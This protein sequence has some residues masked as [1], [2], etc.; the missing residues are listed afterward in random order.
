[1]PNGT[2]TWNRVSS[3]TL[4]VVVEHYPGMSRPAP[5][6]NRVSVP[7]RNGDL[8]FVQDAFNNV[9]RAYEIYAGARS[10]DQAPA[11][12]EDVMS[13]LC[14]ALAA[15]A[16][17]DYRLL[18]KNGYYQLTDSYDPGVIRLGAFIHDTSIENSWNHFGRAT[19]RF[20]CRPERFL[21]SGMT[22]TRYATSGQTVTNPTDRDAKPFV[23]IAGSGAG[24]VTI[25]GT[26]LTISEITDYLYADSDSQNCFR[27][28]SENRNNVVTLTSG[29]FPVLSPGDNTITFTGGVTAVT[30][31]PRWWKL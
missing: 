18:T 28:L 23:M 8:F 26:T 20:S 9:D 12:F 21:T 24:T 3:S 7:G 17:V 27:N 29:S 15:P 10:A 6:Y 2:I 30:I 22:A 11:S 16:V 14:P 5:K 31:T 19:I 4:G 25:N 1:M 13:W